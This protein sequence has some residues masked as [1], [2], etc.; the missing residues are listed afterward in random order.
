MITV[1]QEKAQRACASLQGIRRKI[2]A[3]AVN[4]TAGVLQQVGVYCAIDGLAL[5]QCANT[6]L[7]QQLSLCDNEEDTIPVYADNSS[8]LQDAFKYWFRPSIAWRCWVCK[9]RARVPTMLVPTTPTGGTVLAIEG[10]DN[11]VRG[12]A[13]RCVV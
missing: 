5:L 4:Q 12:V 8:T 6:K 9:L 11:E 13:P 7:Q 1:L 3:F 10:A 2:K